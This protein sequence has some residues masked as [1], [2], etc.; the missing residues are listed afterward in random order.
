MNNRILEFWDGE[1]L[2][3]QYCGNGIFISTVQI[4]SVVPGKNRVMLVMSMIT[5]A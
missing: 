5:T 4:V 3:W 2:D 1:M